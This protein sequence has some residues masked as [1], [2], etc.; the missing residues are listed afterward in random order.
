MI[1]EVERLMGAGVPNER[2]YGFGQE[3]RF[4]F[5]YIEGK[6]ESEEEMIQRLKYAI[7]SFA[8]RQ[9]TWFRKE[10]R[11]HWVKNEQEAEQLIEEFL[12]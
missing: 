12:Q 8:R 6:W 3:Y 9:M 2:L 1:E 11:I 7:H 10:P 5:E 4:C